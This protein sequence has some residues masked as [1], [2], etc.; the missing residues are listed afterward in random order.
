MTVRGG[1]PLDD[2]P[3]AQ[4]T[5]L[6][7]SG[8]AYVTARDLCSRWECSHATL[9]R[10]IQGGYAPKPIRFGPRSVRWAVKD[11]EEFERRPATDSGTR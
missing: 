7:R 10:W 5:A 4:R 3:G 2:V 1:S 6:L 11:I 9:Y 8:R